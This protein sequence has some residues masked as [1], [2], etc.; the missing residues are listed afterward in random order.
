MAQYGLILLLGAGLASAARAQDRVL[1]RG[2]LLVSRAGVAIGREE[3][4]VF[5]GRK[6]APRGF[7]IAVRSFYPPHRADP[8]LSPVVELG[9]DSQ[10]TGIQLV[11]ATGRQRRV[12]LQIDDRRVT[13]RTMTPAGESVRQFPGSEH[14]LIADDSALSLYAILPAL[15]GTVGQ[16]WP[17][18]Q[19]RD[20]IQLSD[21]G[22][23]SVDVRGTVRQLR[24]LMLGSGDEA[25]HLW[26]DANG[27]LVKVEV[28][29]AR[30]TAVRDPDQ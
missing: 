4:T 13:L 28:P 1:D 10:P 8:T 5:E 21:G 17:R 16:I 30:L 22:V 18:E 24:H 9:P 23:E 26:Y 7:T 6:S 3:F 19:R 14:L 15:S 25:R 12:V 11:D 20:V 27:R 29:A 2:T